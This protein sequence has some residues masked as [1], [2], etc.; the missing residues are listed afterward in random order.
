[1]LSISATKCLV[2]IFVFVFLACLSSNCQPTQE[3]Q[4]EYVSVN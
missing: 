4:K 3:S 1:M 2:R